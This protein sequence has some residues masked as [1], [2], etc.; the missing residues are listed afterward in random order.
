ML[1]E[2]ERW[3]WRLHPSTKKGHQ[4]P[5]SLWP[6]VARWHR[7]QQSWSHHLS[8]PQTRATLNL[9]WP[10]SYDLNYL[11]SP[12]LC[13][14]GQ[15]LSGVVV[16]LAIFRLWPLSPMNGT[17]AC[18]SIL[19]RRHDDRGHLQ[20]VAARPCKGHQLYFLFSLS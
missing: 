15:P 18:W 14:L 11:L 13:D 20:A 1:R 19:C 6:T 16:T 12:A 8:P 7:I 3:K 10:W 9:P 2:R 17:N 4:V 5:D